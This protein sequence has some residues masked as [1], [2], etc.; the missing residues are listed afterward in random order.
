[1]IE[2]VI[3]GWVAQTRT[4]NDIY[5]YIYIEWLS[6]DIYLCCLVWDPR[7]GIYL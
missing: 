6:S 5:I 7:V 1:M 2:L 3:I 4:S